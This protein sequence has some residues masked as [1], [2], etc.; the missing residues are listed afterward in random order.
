MAIS[1]GPP[2]KDRMNVHE[3]CEH[4]FKLLRAEAPAGVLVDRDYDP[5]LPDALF[6]RHQIIQALLNLARNAMQAVGDG[7][8][9]AAHARS[10][11]NVASGSDPA[12]AGR[13]ASRSRT[14]APVCPRPHQDSLFLRWS[15]G[16]SNGTGLGLAVA[17]EMVTRTA[18]RSSSQSQPGRTVFSML[19]PLEEALNE[20]SST[21]RL[22]GRRR[23]LDPLGAGARAEEC[24]MTP[25]VFEAAESALAAL[26]SEAAPMC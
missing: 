1:S 19:L 7:P 22:A 13:R 21:A 20:R 16:R 15:P 18:G 5:S 10:R 23:C 26:R 4:V 9:H 11:R 24:G 3:I 25:R 14:T 2:Q 17:Q 12:P 8:H 6:D